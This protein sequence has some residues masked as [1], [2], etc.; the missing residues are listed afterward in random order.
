ML[1]ETWLLYV[2]TIFVVIL[3]PGPL[4]LFMVS[5]SLA[6]GII[7]TAPAFIGGALASS[8]YL[9]ASATGLGALLIASEGLFSILKTIGA[10]YLIYLGITTWIGA[11][12]AK[13]LNIKVPVNS[14]VN[15]KSMFSKA[16]FLGASN[17]KD[18]LFFIAFLPQFI[19]QKSPLLSQ[20]VIIVSTW[21]IVDL[22]CKLIYGNSAHL[23]RPLLTKAKNK[24]RFDKTIGGLFISTGTLAALIK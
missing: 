8:L 1:F 11:K 15:K 16:F 19:S 9:I 21:I 3:I 5:N 18:L 24:I 17:P 13:G 10:I 20:L 22:I 6:Y 12:N 7:K 4:S 2:T 14:K 23:L